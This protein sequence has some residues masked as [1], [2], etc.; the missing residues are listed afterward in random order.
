[1]LSKETKIR[2]MVNRAWRVF[3]GPTRRENKLTKLAVYTLARRLQKSGMLKVIFTPIIHPSGRVLPVQ[4]RRKSFI[5]LVHRIAEMQRPDFQMEDD[6]SSTM[7]LPNQIKYDT[8][9]NAID[10]EVLYKVP[11][12]DSHKNP[13]HEATEYVQ[14]VEA[15]A[16]IDVPEI[17]QAQ[18]HLGLN[19]PGGSVIGAVPQQAFRPAF[20]PLHEQLVAQGFIEEGD[21]LPED[22]P[23]GWEP[24][25]EVEP[26]D[27]GLD[28]TAFVAPEWDEDEH[29]VGTGDFNPEDHIQGGMPDDLD[30]TLKDEDAQ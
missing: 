27:V 16:L 18:T 15:P 14:T 28:P 22:P 6:L 3:P 21:A 13:K 10:V 29:A 25:P 26:V 9:G 20:D 19:F 23:I 2:R 24:E 7:S 4:I 30:N 12:E 8:Y 1:M 5:A 11:G 17:Q